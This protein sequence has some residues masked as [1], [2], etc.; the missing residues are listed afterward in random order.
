MS[1]DF[2]QLSERPTQQPL[3][4]LTGAKRTAA[5][6][7]SAEAAQAARQQDFASTLAGQLSGPGASRQHADPRKAAEDFV[8]IALIQ[9]ILKTL[10]ESDKSPPPLGPGPAEKQFRSLADA[11]V[12]RQIVRGGRWP[13][14]DSMVRTL[15]SGVNARGTTQVQTGSPAD[16]ARLAALKNAPPPGV[17]SAPRSK[18]QP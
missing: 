9:P 14:I 16:T 12:A 3:P 17:T 11:Q 7:A 10:R 15:E 4:A 5:E 6:P 13:L 1:I 2:R 8:A 18:E